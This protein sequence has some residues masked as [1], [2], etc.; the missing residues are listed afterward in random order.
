MLERLPARELPEATAVKKS[1]VGG[2]GAA[3]PGLP[4]Q[5][6][7]EATGGLIEKGRHCTARRTAPSP[8]GAQQKEK[9]TMRSVNDA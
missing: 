5:G 4:Q 3:L 1:D 2:H 7:P 9:N 6:L 8:S